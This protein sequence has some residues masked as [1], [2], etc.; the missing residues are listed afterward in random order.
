[1]NHPEPNRIW[2]TRPFPRILKSTD[3]IGRVHKTTICGT[4]LHILSGN[5]G[6][7]GTDPAER[8]EKQGSSSTSSRSGNTTTPANTNV[9]F[10]NPSHTKSGN[11]TPRITLGHE[12]IVDIIAIGLDVKRFK[13]GDRII[14]CCIRSCGK[15]KPCRQKRYGNCTDAI[16]GSWS[17]G[18]TINGMQSNYVRVP[19][20]DKQCLKL[21]DSVKRGSPAEDR[22]LMLCDILPTSYEIGLVDGHMAPGKSMIMI[23][24]GPVGVAGILCASA[25]YKSA[26]YPE[27]QNVIIA[28]DLVDERL[29]KAVAAGATHTVKI[30]QSKLSDGK[31]YVEACKEEV[32][33]ILKEAYDNQD[34]YNLITEEDEILLWED[35]MFSNKSATK[36]IPTEVD[37][38]VE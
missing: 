19:Y 6:D 17:F 31:S 28:I 35:E 11:D 37:L 22:Y 7:M 29:K 16:D 4:D 25:M 2:T 13:V 24:C 9:S 30:D 5:V 32:K 27:K 36:S 10:S 23:G 33:A 15:C 34:K 14:C 12:G 38:V 18:H 3:I 1:M 21:P 8:T 20:A 26:R